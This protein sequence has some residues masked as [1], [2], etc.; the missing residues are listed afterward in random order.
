MAEAVVAAAVLAAAHI[1]P[2][3]ER[4][5][6]QPAVTSAARTSRLR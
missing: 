1:S 4:I 3:A 5:P 6:L 2:V